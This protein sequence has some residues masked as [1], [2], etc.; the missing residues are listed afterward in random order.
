MKIEEEMSDCLKRILGKERIGK[1]GGKKVER[2]WIEC[3]D[4]EVFDDVC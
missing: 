2:D 1:E 3:E 4:E